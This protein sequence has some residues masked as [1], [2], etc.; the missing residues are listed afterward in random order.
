MLLRILSWTAWLAYLAGA[1]LIL[2]TSYQEYGP[3]GSG[4]FILEKGAVGEQPLWRV[5]LYV[6]IISGV[7]C[8][9]SALPQ[10]SRTL[11]RRW[12]SLHR[13]SGR[14]YGMA[15]IFLLAPT[16]FHLAF[17]AKGGLPG[18]L[19]FL[20][21]AVASFH[22]TLAGWRTAMPA[23]RDLDAHRKWM[24]RSFALASSAITFRIYHMAGYMAGLP[25]QTNYIA[26]L[27]L[28]ILG[29]LAVA[30]AIL[31]PRASNLPSPHPIRTP[32]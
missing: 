19:G 16:G 21:L 10:C 3:G 11:L 5:S 29:N 4:Y 20:T 24:L 9:L 13:I 7:V 22:T 15:V 23:T 28:S 2:W 6:H 18:K 26:C 27:W 8:L 1:L 31:R 17:Y 30:E 25:E 14:I 32:S 12:P